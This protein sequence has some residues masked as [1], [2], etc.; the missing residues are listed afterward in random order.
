MIIKELSFQRD[1]FSVETTKLQ[2]RHLAVALEGSA[3]LRVQ[4]EFD[5]L[6]RRVHEEARLRDAT[7][8]Y[9]DMSKLEFL[10]SG[11]F[12]SLCTWVRLRN[13][14]GQYKIRILS[15]PKYYWQFR[16]LNALQMLAPDVITVKKL[17]PT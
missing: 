11:C 4:S 13:H 12:K 2:A 14:E 5:S 17:E 16:S 10:N 6:I 3:D 8:V 1:S 9:V 15:N 7:M